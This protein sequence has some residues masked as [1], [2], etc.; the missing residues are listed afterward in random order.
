MRIVVFDL[1]FERFHLPLI[2]QLHVV[3]LMLRVDKMQNEALE[4]DLLGLPDN[5]ELRSLAADDLGLQRHIV[6]R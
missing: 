6:L 4:K 2:K 3:C 1:R 5:L